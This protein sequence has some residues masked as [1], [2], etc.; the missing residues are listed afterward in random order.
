MRNI[1]FLSGKPYVLGSTLEIKRD[2]SY[3]KTTCGSIS[4]GYWKLRGDTL[5]LF[6]QKFTHRND[7]LNSVWDTDCSQSVDTF[8]IHPNG[9]LR[10]KFFIKEFKQIALNY[11]VKVK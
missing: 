9:E 8:Y 1:L 7:S 6:C 5:L 4:S 10:Q 2:S 11:F 3:I